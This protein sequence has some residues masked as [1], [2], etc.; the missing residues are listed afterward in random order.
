MFWLPVFQG[1]VWWLQPGPL[2][3]PGPWMFH[4][5]LSG[6]MEACAVTYHHQRQCSTVQRLQW[7]APGTCVHIR[8]THDDSQNTHA[9]IRPN[10]INQNL[11]DGDTVFRNVFLGDSDAFMKSKPSQTLSVSGSIYRGCYSW[12][13]LLQKALKY[14]TSSVPVN[15]TFWR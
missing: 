4:H 13:Y 9:P 7:P 6:F 3:V 14:P 5:Q 12:N 11:C 15:M 1:N 2:N 10:L 8:I